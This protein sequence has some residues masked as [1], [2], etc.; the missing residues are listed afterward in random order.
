MPGA[1]VVL[2][3][4]VAI[5]ILN[6]RNDAA[7]WVLD[8]EEILLSVPVLGELRYG[9]LNSARALENLRRIDELTSRCRVLGLHQETSDV[10]ARL[11]LDLKHKAKPIP[12]N[13]LWIAAVCVE[14]E[15]SLATADP[16]FN[17]VSRLKV[18]APP[19]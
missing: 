16:H 2:D 8:F 1:E 11:R 6:G 4:N 18:V 15:H 12:E 17:A 5:A 9:A 3:T 13:D 19:V 10:Y 14:H 7:R